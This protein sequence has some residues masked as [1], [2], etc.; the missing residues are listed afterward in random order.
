MEYHN[1]TPVS[2]YAF[3]TTWKNVYPHDVKVRKYKSSC[4]H[5]N[6]CTMLSEMRRKFRDK[7]GRLEITKLFAFHRLSTM[8]ER[9]AYYDRRIGGMLSAAKVLSTL[10]RM[11]YN[12]IAVCCHGSAMESSHICI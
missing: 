3:L 12:R 10:F 8:G 5:C 6:T 9:R 7:E 4:G 2:Y 11:V 1:D